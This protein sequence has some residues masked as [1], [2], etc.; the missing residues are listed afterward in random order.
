MKDK[1]IKVLYV[2]NDELY[3]KSIGLPLSNRFSFQGAITE[4][5]GLEK[6]ADNSF[7]VVISDGNLI[8]DGGHNNDSSYQGG[9]NIVKAAKQKGAYTIGLSSEPECFKRLAGDYI[10]LNYSKRGGC[11]VYVLMDIIREKP[12]QKEFDKMI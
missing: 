10:D 2:D 5:E 9:I 12:T 4:K 8:P 7:D 6:I 1:S 3:L 11:D